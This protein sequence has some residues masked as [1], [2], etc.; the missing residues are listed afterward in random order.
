M[1][2]EKSYLVNSNK[3]KKIKE[4]KFHKNEIHKF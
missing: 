4:G 3:Q 2:T 1:A